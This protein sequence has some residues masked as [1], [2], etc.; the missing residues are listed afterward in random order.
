M[1]KGN[2]VRVTLFTFVML[3]CHIIY[4]IFSPFDETFILSF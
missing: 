2:Y 1:L 4:V 3:E